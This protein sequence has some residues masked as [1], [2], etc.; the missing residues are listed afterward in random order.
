MAQITKKDNTGDE[1]GLVKEK[2]SA[3]LDILSLK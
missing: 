2:V 3:I 1:A